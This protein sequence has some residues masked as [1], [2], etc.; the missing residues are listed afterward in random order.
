MWPY[1]YAGTS[2]AQVKEDP[3]TAASEYVKFLDDISID[4]MWGPAGITKPI[5]SFG[6]LG[7]D[8]F[9]IGSDGNSIVH[10]QTNEMPMEEGEYEEF[11]KD[12]PTYWREILL[13][14]RLPA[15]QG[16]YEEA[17][18]AFVKALNA[19]RPF[20]ETNKLI[21]DALT[22]RGIYP[23]THNGPHYS[24]PLDTLFDQ[25]RGMK[26]TLLDLRRRPEVVKRA[27]DKIFEMDMANMKEKP[28]DYADKD[29][30]FCGVTVYH[31]ACFLNPNQFDD[32]FMHYLKKGF[33][34]FFEA[35]VHMFLK[36]EG[37]FL[38]TLNRYRDLPKGAMVI[39]LEEDD[40]FEC[41]QEIGDWA[42]LATGITADLLKYGSKQQCIDYVKKCFDTFAPGG[43]F[44]F[45]QDRPLMGAKDA[46]LD[47][48]IAVYEFANA[49]GKK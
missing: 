35:G 21:G 30:L 17:Y 29:D 48:L 9:L 4:Y 45:M 12:P 38:H 44:I 41:H 25:V 46:N 23:L 36:G 31:S 19:F 22:D 6:E 40:P 10:A 43:G 14:K 37:K 32:M 42:T 24:V 39:M 1:A 18:L 2:Y 26:N 7:S 49:Y 28:S 47:N 13:R 27:C 20:H 8:S 3:K 34:K 11:I 5:D 15:F 33:M 16:S